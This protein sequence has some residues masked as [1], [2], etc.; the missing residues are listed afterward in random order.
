LRCTNNRPDNLLSLREALGEDDSV[1]A[2]LT[3][4]NAKGRRLTYRRIGGEA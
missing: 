2:A 3:V 4:R 1:R